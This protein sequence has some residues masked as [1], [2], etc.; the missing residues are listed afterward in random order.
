MKIWDLNNSLKI[1][2]WDLGDEGLELKIIINCLGSFN[3]FYVKERGRE[4]H[5]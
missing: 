4:L 5:V 1:R 3:L 2:I